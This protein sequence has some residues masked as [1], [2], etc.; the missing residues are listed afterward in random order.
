MAKSSRSQWVKYN[1][2]L[3]CEHVIHLLRQLCFGICAYRRCCGRF[4]ENLENNVCEYEVQT[5]KL[6]F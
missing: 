1:I 3:L 4:V 2:A 6:Y 5:C